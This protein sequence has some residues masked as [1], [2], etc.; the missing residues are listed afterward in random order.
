LAIL[1]QIIG[2][3]LR[4]L[5]FNQKAGDFFRT[6]YAID[7]TQAPLLI[8]GSSRA[9]HHFVPEVLDSILE[10]TSYNSGRDDFELL[11]NLAVF[12]AATKRYQPRLLI[13]ELSPKEIYNNRES[14]DKLSSL[15]PYFQGHPEIRDII[16]MRSPSESLKLLSAI[17]PF[18]SQLIKM[19]IGQWNLNHDIGI[20]QAGY[21][22][23]YGN[24]VVGIANNQLPA[25][26]Y[27]PDT[28]KLN[29]LKEITANSK[30]MKIPLIVIYSPVFSN[31]GYQQEIG[32]ISSICAAN[33]ALFWNY[34]Q[35]LRFDNKPKYFRDNSHLN[36][37]GARL[38]SSIIADSIRSSGILN[39]STSDIHSFSY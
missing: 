14:Y 4:H 7:S 35:D 39:N 18:N 26:H 32:M 30:K 8:I 9:S 15:L 33:G 5:Y 10:I 23:L 2:A 12:R 38:F 36:N 6:T 25:P 27:E 21:V 37:S 28:N 16:K 34:S 1:D 19:L 29:A 17:Y 11:H 20:R 13:L 3:Y 24:H 31:A 22:P